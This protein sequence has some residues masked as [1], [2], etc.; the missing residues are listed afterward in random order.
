[1]AMMM[2]VFVT[3]DRP[4]SKNWAVSQQLQTQEEWDALYTKH[5]PGA[6]KSVAIAFRTAC[7]WVVAP[8]LAKDWFREKFF[9]AAAADDDDSK[10]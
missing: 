7:R 1:M 2:V 3:A 4:T 9:A 10:K 8:N 5:T 6:S